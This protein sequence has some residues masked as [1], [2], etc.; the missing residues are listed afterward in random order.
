LSLEEAIALALE[1]QEVAFEVPVDL[2]QQE[3]EVAAII[4]TKFFAQLQDNAEAL[5]R[6]LADTG[7]A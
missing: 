5:R 4:G 7:D 3:Q 2:G 6:E 1:P